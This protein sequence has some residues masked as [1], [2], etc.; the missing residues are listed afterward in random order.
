MRT[1]LLERDRTETI[2]LVDLRAQYQSIRA[3]IDAAM[4]RVVSSGQFILGPEGAALERELAGYCGTHE[5]VAVASGT[6]ALE[7]ALRACG[8][9]PGDEVITSAFSFFAPAEA[10]VTVGA[11]PVFVDID[12]VTYA[13]NPTEVEA[14]LTPR[15]KALL[16]VHLY[17]HPCDMERLSAIARAH[18]LKMVEDCAQA[19]GARDHGVRVGS[20]GDAGCLSFYPSKN[21]GGYGDGGMVV[22]ND[23]ELAERIRLLR[24]HGSRDRYHHL[25]IG[26]NS[27]LDELQAAILRVKLRYLEGWI[28]AR[29]SHARLYTQTCSRYGLTEVVL[30]REQSEC[31]HVYSLYT[32]R[33]HDR[34][35]VQQALAR[36]G[37]ATQVAYPSTVPSQPAL[38]PWIT[39]A[40]GFPIASQAARDV[41]SLPL[42]P[43]LTPQM[44]ERVV[45]HLAHRCHA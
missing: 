43:E 3:E 44:I 11:I 9:G 14:R 37:I 10:I 19:I 5:A 40:K 12:P 45:S 41:L 4:T 15:T 34:D 22:T 25:A 35:R 26:K 32:V 18:K 27:R 1:H 42:Y 16:P 6:D 30:P 23:P 36:D 28:E 17:G 13:L 20:F 2:P 8:I 38:Q 29:R 31:F 33:L 39:G 7:L 24:T 21:L